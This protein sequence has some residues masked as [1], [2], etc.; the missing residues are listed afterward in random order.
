MLSRWWWLVYE[1]FEPTRWVL[2]TFGPWG[3]F[4]LGLQIALVTF[5]PP[6]LIVIALRYAK[7]GGIATSLVRI[8]GWALMEAYALRSLAKYFLDMYNDSVVFYL[9]LSG[10]SGQAPFTSASIFS[11]ANLLFFIALVLSFSIRIRRYIKATRLQKKA[12]K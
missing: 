4:W 6:I 11:L 8:V 12:S 2:S 1:E 7:N 3:P 9:I 5:G 10:G